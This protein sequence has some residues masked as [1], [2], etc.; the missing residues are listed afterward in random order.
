MESFD[1]FTKH[2]RI[3]R[4]WVIKHVILY[5]DILPLPADK[6]V[7]PIFANQNVWAAKARKFIVSSTAH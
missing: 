7:I 3:D 4:R 2:A 6:D 1:C 5:K